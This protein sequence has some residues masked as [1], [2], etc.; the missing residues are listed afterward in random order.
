MNKVVVLVAWVR[1]SSSSWRMVRSWASRA[2]KGSS[3]RR[4]SG[5]TA[6]AR[7]MATRCRMPPESAAG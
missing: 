6:R 1:A 4:I 3:I 5:S 2:A 7:A